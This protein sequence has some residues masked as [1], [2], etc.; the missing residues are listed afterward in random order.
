M[1]KKQAKILVLHTDWVKSVSAF[2]NTSFK[3][4]RFKMC[5]LLSTLLLILSVWSI[6]FKLIA[7]LFQEHLQSTATLQTRM[8]ISRTSLALAWEQRH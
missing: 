7:K 6:P 1:T 5:V 8:L 4:H 3:R 2:W